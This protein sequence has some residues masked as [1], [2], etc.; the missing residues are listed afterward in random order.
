[1]KVLFIHNRYRCEGGEEA[2]VASEM[3]MLRGQGHKVALYERSNTELSLRSPLRLLDFFVR[4]AIWSRQTY[5]EVREIV[6]KEKP[7]IAHI[8][9][10]FF[11]ISPSVYWA[12]WEEKIPVVQSLHNHRLFCPNSGKF[13]RDGRICEEC[14]RDSCL[15]ALK[16][17][18]G[19][20]SFP[21]TLAA[22]RLLAFHHRK[23]TFSDKI[24]AYI[25]S[26][27]FG[28]KKFISLG[29]CPEK[30]R[31]KPNFIDLEPKARGAGGYALFAGRLFDNKGADVLTQAC[32]KLA[33]SSVKIV[34]SGDGPLYTKMRRTLQGLVNVEMTGW[35]PDEKKFD[36]LRNADFL[37][38][39]SICYENMPRIVIE[40]YA[41]GVPV[42]ASPLGGM[43]ELVR[44]QITGLH[45]NLGDSGDL[46]G[47]IK[48]AWEHPEKVRQMG[49]QALAEYN[50]K[51]TMQKNYAIAADVY[52]ETIE[53]FK[54]NAE[55]E[56]Y[57]NKAGN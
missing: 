54:K 6:R 20:E 19:R 13:F 22:I 55:R 39:P 9:N 38:F 49:E 47:K 53:R 43:R 17:C 12:L 15:P 40:A 48:W 35:L 56:G 14:D 28:R 2:V 36:Y 4:G 52:A 46:A 8:H 27:E 21:M 7:D 45:F 1:M 44:D 5:A 23:K 10:I 11:M 51:Y 16:H 57:G 30:I 26:T 31:V 50:G 25:V 24:T 18:C 3:A 33:G 32:L 29:L 34:I 41:C 42:I 37:I